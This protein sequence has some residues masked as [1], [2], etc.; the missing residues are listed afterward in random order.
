MT[1]L[2][3]LIGLC[4]LIATAACGTDSSASTARDYS[5]TIVRTT[6]GV[7]HITSDNWGDLGFGQ[8]YAYAQDN[9][10]LFMREVVVSNGQSARYFGEDGGDTS[11]DYVYTFFN[12]EQM[13][14]E[15]LFAGLSPNLRE[16]L[17]GYAAGF[18]QYLA[19]TG[20]D[21]LPEECAGADWVRPIT[22]LDV[23]KVIRK[24][25]LLA[26]TSNFTD[27][28]MA[29]DPPSQSMARLMP[30]ES[31]VFDLRNPLPEVETVGS[32]GYGIGSDGSQTDFG[33][34][35]GNPHFPWR[36]NLR[37]YMQHLTIPGQLDI[38]GATIT[39]LPLVLIGFNE[40]VAWSHTVST[41]R[42]F[43]IYEVVIDEDDPMK[44]RYDDELRD[45]EEVPVTIEVMLEDGTI[46]EQTDSIYFTQYGPV[47]DGGV[48]EDLLSGWPNFS[49]TL[50]TYRDAN[51]TNNRA[52]S[53]WEAMD[54]AQSIDDIEEALKVI[55]NPWTNTIAADRN[56][57]A[58]YADVSVVPHVSTEKL[59]DCN[60]SFISEQINNF[61][62]PALNGSRS[63]CEWG[64]DSDAPIEGIFGYENLPKLRTRE[65]VGN[66]NDSYWLSNPDDL[67]T[68][69]SRLI[70]REEVPQSLRTRQGFTQAE[71][72]MDASDGKSDTP[73]YDLGLLQDM[74]YSNMDIAEQM[75]R[76]DVVV[77]CDAVSDW[78][79]G[80]CDPDTDGDQAYSQ[81]PVLAATACGIIEDWDGLYNLDSVGAQVWREFWARVRGT[82]NLW[83]VPFDATDPVNT[84]N[85]L[86]DEDP[87]VVEGVRCAI[88]GAVDRL[89]Q[90]EVALDLTWGE[91]QYRP[92]GD[93]EGKTPIHGGRGQSTFSVIGSN[94]VDGEGYSDIPAGNSYIHTVTWDETECP[95]AFAVLT[96]SQ[97]SN[98]ASPH[99]DDMTEVYS[100]GSW[101][102][103]P[104]CPDDVEAETIS[105][106]EV[107]TN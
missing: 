98:P 93:G 44:Y 32:N 23:G 88:G 79:S 92:T 82:E 3:G 45:I 27:A 8:A 46:E 78:S 100:A 96:Y 42:R 4:G 5:A 107:G 54:K 21:N 2:I 22:T 1:R 11:A 19:D 6:Y 41:A 59:D 72:R 55:G 97:S 71:A 12:S 87:G 73:G 20:T 52:M 61:G 51:L 76:A 16:G 81:N 101:N 53:F 57:E 56:G 85:T 64:T 9:F 75:T 89:V 31:S 50:L 95:D 38:M 80:D 13:I 94:L 69:F 48:L 106:T 43:T 17:E 91:A 83:A 15:G 68:G 47:I 105:E 77:L 70:G 34:Q 29:A 63:E 37:F 10:C 104:Y 14:E 65:Y 36:G 25:I 60:D 86:N 40:N 24:L 33:L 99:Y 18:S 7:P 74:L 62:F 35:L 66:S 39:G 26:S 102:D 84:P 103:M 67:L 49:G 28:I 30:M 58:L 90:A